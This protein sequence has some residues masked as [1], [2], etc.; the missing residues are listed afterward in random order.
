M[1]HLSVHDRLNNVDQLKFVL[2]L[3][4]DQKDTVDHMNTTLIVILI[5]LL[6]CP[7][8]VFVDCFRVDAWVCS[9]RLPCRSISSSAL[10]GEHWGH[11]DCLLAWVLVAR[12]Y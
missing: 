7:T 9:V 4:R 12:R 1:S 5:A 3:V 6:L 8:A 2:A 11:T 10:P